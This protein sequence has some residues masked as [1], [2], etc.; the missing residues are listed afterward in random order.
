M[1]KMAKELRDP[2][3]AKK[4]SSPVATGGG[5]LSFQARTQALYL[6]NML[7]GIPTVQSLSGGR[8][9]A[10]RYEARYTGAHTD[11]IVCDVSGDDGQLWKCFVQ[12]KRSIDAVE[13]DISFVESVEAAWRDWLDGAGFQRARDVLVIASAAPASSSLTAAQRVCELARSSST[14]QDLAQKLEA[15]H[16]F[17]KS[18]VQAWRVLQTI[19]RNTLT[20]RYTDDELFAFVRRLRFD[21]HNL[22]FADTQ[23]SVLIAAL[24]GS[25][26]GQPEDG[27]L[28]WTGLVDFCLEMGQLPGTA[29]METW[30]LKASEPLRRAFSGS[31]AGRAGLVQAWQLLVQRAKLQLSLV[32]TELP[33]KIH[34]PRQNVHAELLSKLNAHQLIVV[35]GGPG[36][37]KSGIVASIAPVLAESGPLFFFRA[38]ELD[39]GS[40]DVALAAGGIS[41]GLQALSEGL[42]SYTSATVVIDSLEKALEYSKRGAIEELIELVHRN[43]NV[44]LVVTVRSHALSA[45]YANFLYPLS[46]TVVEVPH[47]DETELSLAMG[48]GEFSPQE[49]ADAKLRLVLRAPIYLRL[50]LASRKR[51]AD[52][53]SEDANDLRR[54]LWQECVAPSTGGDRGLAQRRQAVFEDICFIRTDRLSQFVERPADGEAIEAL[55]RDELLVTDPA[56]RVAPAHDV[57]EDWALFFRVEREVRAS[58]QNWPALFV[59][60][61]T[62]AG[63]RRAFRVWTSERAAVNDINAT[64]LLDYCLTTTDASPLWRD[65]ALIGLLRSPA[66]EQLVNRFERE[67]SR[68]GFALLKR[69]VH[70]LRVACTGP[71]SS[72]PV[73]TEAGDLEKEARIRL[74]MTAPMGAAW[75]HVLQLVNAHKEALPEEAWG[76][77]APLLTDAIG[78]H[79][80]YVSNATTKVIFNLADHYLSRYDGPWRGDNSL[81]K[82]YFGFLIRSVGGELNRAHAYF[83]SLIHRIEAMPAARDFETEQKLE[84][85]LKFVNSYALAYFLPDV[86]CRA[87][88]AM[89]VG[90]SETGYR[91]AG[92]GREAEFGIRERSSLTFFPASC[93]TGPFRKLLHHSKGI[94]FVVELANESASAFARENNENIQVFAGPESPNAT[95]HLH[96]ME[97]WLAYRG[98]GSTPEL[99]SSALMALEERLLDGAQEGYPVTTALEWILE[100][101][102]S[103]LTTGVVSSVVTAY[104]QQM[105][106][107]LL[108]LFKCPGFFAADRTRLASEHGALAVHGGHDGLDSERQKERLNSNKLPHRKMDLEGLVLRLQLEGFPLKQKIQTILDVHNHALAKTAELARDDYWRI[109]LKRMDSRELHIGP[110]VGDGNYHSL[111]ITKL[112]EDLKKKAEDAQSRMAIVNRRAILQLWASAVIE[113]V[114]PEPL[115]KSADEV[116]HSLRIVHQEEADE[117]TSFYSDLDLE[118]ACAIVLSEM[119]SNTEG[120]LWARCKLLEENVSSDSDRRDWSKRAQV[121]ATRALV[122]MV[123]KCPSDSQVLDALASAVVGESFDVRMALA[124]AVA[125]SLWQ[126]TPE[127]AMSYTLGLARYAELTELVVHRTYDRRQRAYKAAARLARW[128]TLRRLRGVDLPLPKIG[129]TLENPKG[130]LIALRAAAGSPN[131]EWRREALE[132]LVSRAAAYESQRDEQQELDYPSRRQVAEFLAMDLLGD[133]P[134]FEDA[135]KCVNELLEA[136]PG[137]SAEVLERTLI[138]ADR[139]GYP[140]IERLWKTW[141]M[142]MNKVFIQPSLR[143]DSRHDSAFDPLLRVLLLTSVPWTTGLDNLKIFDQ[144]PSF[145]SDCLSRVG[146]SRKGF[147]ECVQ[148]MATIGRRS[149][150]PSGMIALQDALA[151]QPSAPFADGNTRWFAEKVCRLAVHEHREDLLASLPLRQATL[152][153]LDQLIESGSS[154]AFQLRDYLASTPPRQSGGVG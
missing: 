40:L 98:M 7:T 50:A 81:A 15:P 48:Q 25:C 92:F 60:L 75:G 131:W 133:G 109:A 35:T 30:R 130:W 53:V 122:A 69:M 114:N 103:S 91:R 72:Q 10:V 19:S 94:R 121:A 36:V 88:K 146:D 126:S 24:I 89:Y 33:N 37:G 97:L 68:S 136:A 101:G 78:G 55:I 132:V 14:F 123:E 51:G 2:L 44:R 11:D 140:N 65:E 128:D 52:L 46:Y 142:A 116:L 134:V 139:M 82:T 6:A 138:A 57:F 154:I 80:W 143:E 62:H 38:D 74:A 79:T 17:D 83:D 105:S 47:L 64:G 95:G 39:H 43:A 115:F 119:G 29:T 5:G 3:K 45:L 147:Q 77:V 99:L 90:T 26:C 141:D 20:D 18:V 34:L 70:L 96:S 54:L 41:A 9:T 100:N 13:S 61:G 148:L 4:I 8:V 113:T 107:K 111:E 125:G 21:I 67:L 58:E 31:G 63:L 118:I 85:A 135:L 59:K 16:L 42:R 112:D 71:A 104:P 23:E 137:F 110:P 145:V 149:S 66:C 108:G 117:D 12:C 102:T 27:A 144:R 153:V 86:V 152:F 49:Q 124:D 32:S 73:G 76:W 1:S 56:G 150:V 22:G 87:L 151:L 129:L 28:L 84:Y 127:L 93:L 106:E 120:G